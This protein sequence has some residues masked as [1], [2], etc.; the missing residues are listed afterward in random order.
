M[1]RNRKGKKVNIEEPKVLGVGAI[2][3]GL[4]DMGRL[5]EAGGPGHI[6]K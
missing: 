2:E 4:M 6:L 1:N 3:D 5:I